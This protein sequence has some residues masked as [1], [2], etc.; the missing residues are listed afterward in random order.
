MRAERIRSRLSEAARLLRQRGA[1]RAWV[2]GSLAARR[3]PHADSDVDLAAEGLLAEGL[4]RTSLDVEQLL[5][6]QVDL[7]RVEEAGESPR[8][9]LAAEGEPIDVFD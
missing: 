7:L 8:A 3:Q 5:G 9:Q 1:R 6:S 2:F 4:M